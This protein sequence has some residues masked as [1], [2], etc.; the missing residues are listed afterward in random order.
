VLLAQQARTQQFLV[1]QEQLVQLV[2]K[3]ILVPLELIQ[4]FLDLRVQQ[5]HKVKLEIQASQAQLVKLAQQVT[6]VHKV[7]LV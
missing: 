7:R 1:L 4:Q 5:V 3:E 6:L 2:H